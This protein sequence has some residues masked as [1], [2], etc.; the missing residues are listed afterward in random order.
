MKRLSLLFLIN[1]LFFLCCSGANKNSPDIS[2]DTSIEKNNTKENAIVS[3]VTFNGSENNYNFSV[4]ITSPDTGCNQ[5]ADWWEVIDLEGN[6]IY[7][8]ILAHSHVE[9][10]PF[11]R[12]GGAVNISEDTEVYVRVH[13]NNSSYGTKAMKGSISKGFTSV[14][15]SADFAI[16]LETT[17]PLPSGC[18]F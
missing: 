2:T 7:R 13:M 18:A 4:T 10:Q 17:E 5:Y 9:E 6:L 8:R 12:S 15:L 16:E 1:S 14:D 3:N 11:T